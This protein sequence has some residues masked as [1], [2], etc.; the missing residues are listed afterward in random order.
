MILKEINSSYLE[1]IKNIYKDSSWTAYLNDDKKLKNA[2][3]NSMYVLGA[4]DNEKLVGFIR[5]VG[6]G[7]HIVFIQDLIVLSSYRKLGIGKSLIDNVYEKYKKVCSLYLVTD[8][9]D[10]KANFFIKSIK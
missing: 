2:F 5:I 7:E 10:R 9:D 3:D 6:D 4:F 1:E 8:K